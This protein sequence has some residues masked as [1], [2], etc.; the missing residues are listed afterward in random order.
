MK[1]YCALRNRMNTYDVQS[2]ELAKMLAMQAPTFSSRMNRRSEWRADEMA[3][4]CRV[5]EIPVADVGIYF[6]MG[7][8]NEGD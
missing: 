6:E 7:V 3:T 4:I 5:L 8:H 1:P 2:Q